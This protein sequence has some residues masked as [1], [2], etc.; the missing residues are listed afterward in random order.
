MRMYWFEL[1]VVADCR[2]DGPNL[3]L[4][5]Q[6]TL[7]MRPLA[8]LRKLRATAGVELRV[9]VFCTEEGKRRGARPSVT[10]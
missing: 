2:T 9:R 4:G 10:A 5:A 6:Y 1:L 8:R 7:L 3:L